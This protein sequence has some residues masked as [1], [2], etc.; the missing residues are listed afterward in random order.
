M[1][2]NQKHVSA[3]K[4]SLV[5]VGI[6][7][8][9]C[10]G[11]LFLL[12]KF[13]KPVVSTP[14]GDADVPII[15][16]AVGGNN[17]TEKYSINIELSEG[18]S[19]P[20]T[21]DLQTPAIGDPLSQE[22]ID[23]I[24]SRLPALTPAPDEQTE[25]NLPQEVLPPPRPG[26][27]IKVTFP[28]FETE[29]TPGALDSGPLQ[30]L[31]FSPEGEIPIAPFISVTFNQPMVP[32]GTIGDLATKDAP[33]QIEPSLPGT[34]RWLGTKT[35]TFEYDSEQIDR[36]P[37]ATEYRVTVP[38]GTKSATGGIL[39]EAVTWTFKTPPPKIVTTYPNNFPQPLDPIFF[40]AFDQRIDPSA[41][42]KN[43]QVTANN[44]V[45]D[46][47]L[48]S[49]A[50]I[51][52]DEQVSQ[53]VENATEGRWLAF[54]AAQPFSTET[55][56]YVTIG[57]GTPSAEGPLTTPVN[58]SYS[59]STYSPLRIQDYSCS[60]YDNS[61]PPL[62]PFYIQFNNP[63][64]MDVYSEDM[65]RVEPEIPGV[66]ANVFGNSIQISGE[67]K[68][69]TTYTV[70]ISG[71]I[72]DIFGQQLG[73]DTRLTF[74]VGKAEPVLVGSGQN[75]ITLDPSASKKIFSVY[76]INYSKVDLKV[77]AVQPSD[78]IDYKNYLRNW[79]Q[80]DKPI[81]VPGKL[82]TDKSLNL[83]IPDD[84][85]TQVDVDLGKFMDGKYGQFI[86]IVEPPSG[87]FES[88][89]DKWRRYSQTT[90]TWVQITQIGLDAFTDHSEM[91]AWATDLKDGSP[92]S[93]VSIQANNGDTKVKSGSDGVVR[94][95]IPN[96]ATYLV[97]SRGD[98][99]AILPRSSYYWYDD[100]WTT[101][102]P[103]DSLRWYVF[104]DR[105]M[106]RPGEEVH[107]KGWLRL[108]GGGQDGGVGLVGD[109]LRLINY[110][111]VD[112]Q[113]NNL[114]T[115]QVEV[116]AIGGFDFV[117]TV[118]EGIN[119]GTAS[120]YLAAESGLAGSQY[121]HP[122]QIQEFR[123]P[124]F[125][126]TA[127]NE[128]SG[129]YFASDSAALAVE[130]KYYAGGGLPNADVTW[131]VTT[132]PGSYSPPNWPDFTFGSWRPWWYFD[133]GNQGYG[134]E[135]QTETFIGK[136][137]ASGTHYLEL[138]FN[139]QGD[140]A[141]DPQPQSVVA[142]STVMDVNRQAWSST[143]TLLVHPS[144]RY[145]GLRSERYFVERGTPLKVDFI[146]TDLDG[147]PKANHQVD[148][149]AGRL[150]WKYSNGNWVEEIADSQTCSLLS[151]PEPATCS[152]ETPVGGSYQIT[153][154]VT[155]DLGRKNQSRFTRW[156]SGGD[157]P[158]SRKVE[159]EKVTLI[160]DK[161]TYQ[162]G[163]VAQ[164]LVQSPFSPAEGILTVTRN[165][166]LYTTRFNIE[167]GSTTLSI[168][169]E[170]KHIPNLSIQVDL[171]GS[172]PRTDDQG[173]AL[174]NI[175]A[176]PA[177]ASGQLNL[178][179][180]PLQRT[181]SLQVTPDEKALEP[182]GETTLTV[183]VKD[184][185]GQPVPDAELAVVVVDEAILALT[186]YQLRDPLSVFY[187]ELPFSL[188]STYGRASILLADP[189]ALAREAGQKAAMDGLNGGGG[190][191][192]AT[193]SPV[194]EMPLP[195]TGGG[196]DE[197]LQNPIIIRSDFNPL[198]TFAPTVRTSS[199]GEARV[200]IKLPDNLTRY[201]IMVV[202]VDSEGI[203][204]GTGESNITARLP[205]MVRPSA[206]R[207]LNFGDKFELPVVLQNQTDS[208]MTVDVAV[209]ATNLEIGNA[210]QRVTVPAN[211]RVEV[212]FPANTIMA[213][214][215]RVQIAATSGNF[216]DAATVELPVYTPAT[217][218]AFATYGVIDDGAIAQ[219]V[220]HPTDVF[221]QFG[222]LEINTSST[223]LQSLT[224]AVLYLVS[225]PY[226]CSEQLASRILAVASLRDVLTAFKADGLPSPS[227]ME[228]AV[229]RDIDR[230]QGMQ[231]SD[232]G[233]PYWR[234]GF[235]SSPFNTIHV[236][237]ALFRAQQ[238]GFDVPAEMQQNALIICA[239]S[240][241]IT[242]PGTASKPAG[243]SAH[244]RF[245][246]AT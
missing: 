19:Q 129:P 125:E 37:M 141:K 25:F 71:K 150:E 11:G 100:A 183:M 178:S 14:G 108:I 32:L 230:L 212:R 41:V 243:R 175:P 211:D 113:G 239:I 221:P 54:R 109:E 15:V 233:F 12:S 95:D 245:M 224:D 194:M 240:K 91:V 138:E 59:F 76:A 208:A 206:P 23:L 151:T 237:H 52:G 112:P 103:S 236:T 70:T 153:A 93:G 84:T 28:S 170:E 213:G 123:R 4:R 75:F 61:C 220:L 228:S 89:N 48:A 152:F 161:E 144:D 120:L 83:N 241:V 18:Q 33:I 17:Q 137:D 72:Q 127:R 16:N 130:A 20:Q 56:I 45:V 133:Y 9:V 166:I 185:D 47:N 218:E 35:L 140:P 24:L 149:T 156:V 97:A 40:I 3:T 102:P 117:F 107:I 246:C 136:T 50:D 36:M 79:Q 73:D 96:G 176:R 67:T 222:G 115:G 5:L 188:M 204:F 55:N 88:E 232:G 57:K 179:I 216:S 119:L 69:Q 227:E 171:V 94:F 39:A 158:A 49:Q 38:A 101:N 217:S 92:L 60:W 223:A 163:D 191:A 190:A 143:T 147:N 43:I 238:K 234:R 182:G 81:E 173:E 167:D 106:Y 139:Q 74:Q 8:L 168:P 174:K 231:N 169:I 110:Q 22:E 196:G 6:I 64:D 42:L 135:T 62:T 187:A 192:A 85:L 235:E 215:V 1:T 30:V 148:I 164:I 195:Q 146:V 58:Q 128:T 65:L 46:I 181:L 10:V 132:S 242:Q 122:F 126:V 193:E 68:G 162:P 134:N 77:Y 29:P 201:R 2:D 124:E 209:R 154:I 159:Q 99:Q 186:N 105:Q 44:Q 118:P 160:P 31:R 214:T 202:A 172:A 142:Q 7:S 82:V 197:I 155:D 157:Q 180:P 177:Y 86:V 207:F 87:M 226:E 184:A 34:W 205:L 210:G 63:L 189:Q 27:I 121:T 80:T 13:L 111:I 198:A 244:T 200:F 51:D 225:Y 53:L 66:S 203:R 165:G 90:I 26:E 21:A 199:N 98:D 116:N 131:Q 78:W 104:D 219:P 114:N 229:S 145:I